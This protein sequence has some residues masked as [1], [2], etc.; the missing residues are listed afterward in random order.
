MLQEHSCDQLIAQMGVSMST[1]Q[2]NVAMMNV[3]LCVRV[4]Y[5]LS[6]IAHRSIA[7]LSAKRTQR[8][9]DDPR[10]NIATRSSRAC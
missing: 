8:V 4:I 10:L 6:P 9:K 2:C 1:E 7:R 3:L 5:R